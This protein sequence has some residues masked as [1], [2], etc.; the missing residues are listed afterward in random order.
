M[1]K[2]R[3]K[4]RVYIAE[5]FGTALLLFIG[6]SLVIFMFGN[7]SPMATL[8][9][10][11]KMRQSIT[12][13]LF[14]GTGA[15]I[16][17]SAI[18]RASGAHINPA[19]TMVFRMFRK[20]DIPTAIYYMIAQL[21]GGIAGSLP[22]FLWGHMGKSIDFG[23]TIPGKDYSI[24]IALTGEIITTFI[25]VSLLILF[26]AFRGT[27]RYTPAVFPLLYAIMVPLE[28]S[29]SGTST[30]PAR[31]LGPSVISGQWFAWW[32][33]WVGPILGAIF[34]SLACSLFARRITSAKIYHFDSPRDGLF[35]KEKTKRKTAAAVATEA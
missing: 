26:L 6:L 30:N 20:I 16:A 15:C 1:A 13:F 19:V 35:R 24:A 11:I 32:I 17:L 18:G 31:S 14:G 33:Y 22:L 2:P 7:G 23:A 12:G 25:M 4:W 21:L 10:N 5:F 27:R 29:I 3:F 9:P 34:A 28:A 8:I